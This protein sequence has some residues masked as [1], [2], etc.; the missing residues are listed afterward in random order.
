MAAP[1]I[2]LPMWYR[3]FA[4]VV[5]SISIVLALI[6]LVDPYLAI[7]LLIFLLGFALFVIGMDRLVAGI[8]G[9]PFGWMGPMAPSWATGSGSVASNDAG[10]GPQAPPKP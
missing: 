7:W 4:I 6:V 9:H 5:G 1:G 10:S 8:T 3:A 2:K